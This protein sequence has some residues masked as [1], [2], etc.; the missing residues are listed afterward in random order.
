VSLNGQG[1]L[2][3][4]KPG[5]G[6]SDLALQLIDGPGSGLSGTPVVAVLVAD[7]QTELSLEENVI[8]A[9]APAILRGM[10]EARGLGILDVPYANAV[11][12]VLVVDLVAAN[13]V[14]RMPGSA[15]MRTEILGKHIARCDIDPSR[16][17]AAARLRLAWELAAHGKAGQKPR[18]AAGSGEA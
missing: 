6:K 11:P 4:G 14:E 17:S 7:D 3:R 8:M 5:S 12:L 2:I 1:V 9:R 13:E 16:P 10:F 15:S 18:L